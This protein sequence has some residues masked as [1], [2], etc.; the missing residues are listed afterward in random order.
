MDND[1]LLGICHTQKVLSPAKPDQEVN[2]ALH[3]NQA[4]Y[5][6]YTIFSAGK[7]ELLKT[8]EDGRLYLKVHIQSRFKAVSEIQTIPFSLFECTPYHDQPVDHTL[9]NEAEVTKEKI[10]KRLQVM[11]NSIPDAQRLLFS[12]EWVN[13]DLSRFSFEIFGLLQFDADLQQEILEMTSVKARLDYL[14]D[15]LNEQN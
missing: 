15:L 11:T 9:L 13:K 12:D 1:L 5:K 10:L 6:P 7:C 2:E 14:L 3:S 4:T 8:L